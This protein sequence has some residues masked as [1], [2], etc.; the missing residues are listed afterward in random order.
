MRFMGHLEH[1]V[2]LKTAKNFIL[3]GTGE[4]LSIALRVPILGIVTTEAVHRFGVDS[5]VAVKLSNRV[6]E[7][8]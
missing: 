8:I 6:S 5:L 1:G 7:Q 3:H 2:S 4:N